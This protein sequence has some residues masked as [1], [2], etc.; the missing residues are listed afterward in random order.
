MGILGLQTLFLFCFKNWVCREK[1]PKLVLCSPR[2]K[3]NAFLGHL[4]CLGSGS[5]RSRA[6]GEEL[7]TGTNL[8][9]DPSTNQGKMRWEAK[10]I[11][12]GQANE[13]CATHWS[14]GPSGLPWE[15]ACNTHIGVLP[16]ER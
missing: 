6:G 11:H 13:Q 5:L 15:N 10:E 9:G 3:G 16:L 4:A 12:A 7:S 1:E 8:E 2:T 14:T